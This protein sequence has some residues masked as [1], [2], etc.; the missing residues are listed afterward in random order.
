MKHGHSKEKSEEAESDSVKKKVLS[1]QKN[2]GS[3]NNL[4]KAEDES[5]FPKIAVNSNMATV[6]DHFKKTL[7]G[8]KLSNDLNLAALHSR[9]AP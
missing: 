7:Y 4:D 1:K 6:A 9:R 2:Y 8:K 5:I 3:K